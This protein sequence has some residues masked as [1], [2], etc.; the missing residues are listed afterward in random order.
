[1]AED[2]TDQPSQDLLIYQ[3]KEPVFISVYGS[4]KDSAVR[5]KLPNEVVA[6]YDTLK[7]FHHPRSRS[8]LPEN[9][10]VMLWPYEY[11]PDPSI[12]WPKEWPGL[13]DPRT[14]R[15][16]DDSFSVYLP[17][18]SL[19]QLRAFLKRRS[20]KGAVEIDGRKWSASIR[21]PFPQEQLWMAPHPEL[22][23]TKR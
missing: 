15:R 7:G 3:G 14:I 23:G 1:M 20:D 4:L 19:A 12:K 22:E 11:A 17:S 10:E 13:N 6:A 16:G 5:S 21:F 8:W 2:A 18:T 9:V